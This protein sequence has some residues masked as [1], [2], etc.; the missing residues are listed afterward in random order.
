VKFPCVS[1]IYASARARLW[2][3]RTI[4]PID[5]VDHVTHGQVR[6][7]NPADMDD[8]FSPGQ[9]NVPNDLTALEK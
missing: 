2:T 5:D 3:W 7:F 8:L 4:R 1:S 9:N 6:R